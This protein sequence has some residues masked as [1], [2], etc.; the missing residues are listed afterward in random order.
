[1]AEGWARALKGD[2]IEP[3]SAGIEVHGLNPK[4]AIVMAEAGVDIS[5]QR[6][7][8]VRELLDTP[9]DCVVTV[10]DNAR[11]TCPS[12]PRPVAK[13]HRSFDDPARAERKLDDDELILREFR[14]VRDD[15]RRFVE[16][17]PE[18]LGLMIDD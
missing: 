3:Y 15:I 6:S 11:E 13:V 10:C 12:F 17:M 8:H 18:N 9:F 4:A 16:E 5:Q 1:M 14:R 2:S 7:K